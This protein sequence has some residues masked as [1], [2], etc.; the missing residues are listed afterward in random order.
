VGNGCA[1]GAIAGDVKKLVL[2]VFVAAH[3]AGV[4]RPSGIRLFGGT[5]CG[6]TSGEA[7]STAEK[8]NGVVVRVSGMRR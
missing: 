1:E 4:R 7:N 6:G 2:C 3:P 5:V 8:A